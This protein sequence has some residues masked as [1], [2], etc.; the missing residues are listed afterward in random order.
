M[1]RSSSRCASLARRSSTV[2]LSSCQA[3]AT[4]TATTSL[5]INSSNLPST[6]TPTS[7]LAGLQKLCQAVYGAALRMACAPL[8]GEGERHNTALLVSGVLRRE[9]EAAEQDGGSGFNRDEA[10][11]LFEEIF[12][13]DT[14]IKARRKVFEADFARDDSSE[15]PG[16]PALGQAHRRGCGRRHR[17][18]AARL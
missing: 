18:H 12:A 1:F 11:R 13:H 9:V 8:T 16:Y 3:R 17:P 4:R 2:S 5:S 14:E 7:S 15:L 6:A 10:R